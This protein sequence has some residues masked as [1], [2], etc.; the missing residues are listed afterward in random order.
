[1]CG[2]R[3]SAPIQLAISAG[4]ARGAVNVGGSAD[5]RGDAPRAVRLRNIARRA[6]RKIPACS[7]RDPDVASEP[8]DTRDCERSCAGRR[9]PDLH[10][11]ER[12]VVGDGPAVRELLHLGSKRSAISPRGERGVRFDQRREPRN[13]EQIALGIGRLPKGRRSG[14]P[15][16]RQDRGSASIPRR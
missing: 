14:T 11:H 5:A 12:A 7:G 15:E 1:M 13:A 4:D 9:S 16:C 10:H 3:P 6:A 2:R 8:A